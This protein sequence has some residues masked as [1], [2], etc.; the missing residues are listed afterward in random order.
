MS[1][2]KNSQHICLLN[3]YVGRT[4]SHNIYIY[5]LIHVQCVGRTKSHNMYTPRFMYVYR[6]D[7]KSLC[8]ICYFSS[9]RYSKHPRYFR[10]KN[11]K[12]FILISL[13]QTVKTGFFLCWTY[14]SLC[15]YLYPLTLLNKV[16]SNYPFAFPFNMSFINVM[17]EVLK[18]KAYV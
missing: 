18:V 10:M 16:S 2:D 9:T 1:Q 15:K 7:R 11:N 6:Q 8:D 14:K 12:S 5:T 13:C 17:N 3:M 4:R